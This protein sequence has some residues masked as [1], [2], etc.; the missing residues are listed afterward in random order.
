MI[1]CRDLNLTLP[2]MGHAGKQGVVNLSFT[3]TYADKQRWQKQLALEQEN[4][5]FQQK[6]LSISKIAPQLSDDDKLTRF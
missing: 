6:E 1:I 3:Y 4:E 5:D 2:K